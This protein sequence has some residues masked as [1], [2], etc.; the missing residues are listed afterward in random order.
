LSPI[1][2]AVRLFLKAHI[3]ST[4][5]FGI[6]SLIRF[7]FPIYENISGWIYENV[8]AKYISFLKQ[9][10]SARKISKVPNIKTKGA[11]IDFPFVILPFSSSFSFEIVIFELIGRKKPAI[12]PFFTQRA[13]NSQKR[14]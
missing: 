12:L 13:A 7:Y 14:G 2:E 11:I 10:L 4:C 1:T 6:S 9:L 8:T 5:R 3:S